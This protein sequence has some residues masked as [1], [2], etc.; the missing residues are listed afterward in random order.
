V[1]IPTERWFILLG[2]ALGLYGSLVAGAAGAGHLAAEIVTPLERH[3]GQ[4]AAARFRRIAARLHRHTHRDVRLSDAGLALD[5][6]LT[7][8]GRVVVRSEAFPDTGTPA[9]QTAAMLRRTDQLRERVNLHITQID[10][11]REDTDALSGRVG[12]LAEQTRGDI[13]AALAKSEAR[14]MRVSAAGLPG[15]ALSIL[16]TAIPSMLLLPGSW[17]WVTFG[18]FVAVAVA[19]VAWTWRGMVTATRDGWEITRAATTTA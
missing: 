13:D 9:E 12:E 10:A 4:P 7:A 5:G 1:P 18:I 2:V 14:S 6:I 8:D 3:V 11:L 17:P 16:L 15:I 19:H